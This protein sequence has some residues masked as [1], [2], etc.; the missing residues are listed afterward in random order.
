M[1]LILAACAAVLALWAA[2]SLVGVLSNAT[3]SYVGPLAEA[4]GGIDISFLTSAVVA[5]V[6]Y[7]ALIELRPSWL[8]QPAAGHDA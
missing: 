4:A 2:G 3:D 1:L 5:A 6:V 7:R 8:A